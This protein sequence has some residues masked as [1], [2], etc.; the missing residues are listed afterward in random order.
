MMQKALAELRK[1]VNLAYLIDERQLITELSS[2]LT[3]Y[4]PVSTGDR[5]KTI[6]TAVREK[7]RRQTVIEAFLQEYQLNSQEGVV[8]MGI[9]EALLRI[10]D[11]CTQDLFLQ[12][13]LT[14]ADWRSHLQ[15]SDSPLVN[16]ATKALLFAG[17]FE[18]DHGPQVFEQL[19]SRMGAPLIRT[20]LKQAMQHLA[21][22]F[23]FAESM[24]EAIQRSQQDST[25]RY[26]FDRLGEA[27]LTQTDS[28][29]YF[30]AYRSAIDTLTRAY[31][32]SYRRYV[33]VTSRCSMFVR[34]KS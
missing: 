19:L 7:K 33:P 27:A 21:L 22:Q 26:S 14:G 2:A 25:F 23:V 13:K 16:V 17:D 30:Q 18:A 5:A 28:E 12:E 32:L 34:S 20:V 8:L 1:A 6:V 3:G 10:P 9:A 31:R 29:Y 15:H 4:D 11:S 24:Q